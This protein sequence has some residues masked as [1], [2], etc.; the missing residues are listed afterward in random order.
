M[1]EDYSLLDSEIPSKFNLVLFAIPS[2]VAMAQMEKYLL[3]GFVTHY[4]DKYFGSGGFGFYSAIFIFICFFIDDYGTSYGLQADEY[5][6]PNAEQINWE[7][8]PH[9]SQNIAILTRNLG[10]TESTAFRLTFW[11]QMSVLLTAHYFG[12][13]TSL[14]RAYLILASVVKVWAG[15]GWW[16]VTPTNFTFFDNLY[17]PGRPTPYRL[18]TRL[19][20]KKIKSLSRMDVDTRRRLKSERDVSFLKMLRLTL[21]PIVSN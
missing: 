4:T 17:K 15:Y 2:W 16:F 21:F 6:D 1:Q 12:L 3:K 18:S 19:M 8:N 20:E 11:Y 7:D 10:I 5:R 9:M 13:T 14:L